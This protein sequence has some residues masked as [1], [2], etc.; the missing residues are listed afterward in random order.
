[1]ANK[2]L[3][4]DSINVLTSYIDQAVS[5][6]TKSGLVLTLQAYKYVPFGETPEIPNGGNYD[7][8][9]GQISWP[10]EGWN[11]LKGVL[12]DIVSDG[13]TIE[14]ALSNGRIY[15]SS[16]VITGTGIPKWSTPIQISGQNGVS[17]QFEYS[18]D[19]NSEQG[20]RTKTPQG[21]NAENRVEYVW[22]RE[23]DG[24][25]STPT[26][27]AMYSQDASN[28]LWKYCVTKDLV[29]PNK[30]SVGDSNWSDD[31]INRN[32][33]GE[34]PYMWM[35]S[36]IVPSGQ[37]AHDGAW[38]TPILFGHWGM[39]GDDGQVPNYSVTFYR[40]TD[41]IDNVP[42]F[43]IAE[44]DL[45]EDVVY[46]NC[47]PENDESQKWYQVP[48]YS[49]NTICWHIVVNVD[50]STDMVTGWS[51]I[52]RYSPLDGDQL[53]TAVT[54]YKYYWSENQNPPTVELEE[55][56]DVPEYKDDEQNGSLWMIT[57]MF[58]INTSNGEEIQVGNWTTP[59]KITGPRGP[60]S[61]DYRIETRYNIG[62]STKPKRLPTEDEWKVTPPATTADYPYVWAINYF[63][64]YKMK[65]D[66][67][68]NADGEYPIVE[69]KILTAVPV[70][71]NGYFR[72]SGLDGED[73]NRRNTIDYV[74]TAKEVK[75]S[76]FSQTNMYISNSDVDTS[77]TIELDQLSFINGYTAKF[78]N[79]GTGYMIINTSE[80]IPFSGSCHHATTVHLDPQ[81]SIELVCY[82]NGNQKELLI[83]GK[84]L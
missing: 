48:T 8:N 60:I 4:L 84:Q 74:T 29:V 81:E 61:Y 77:Y 16:A 59:V 20:T 5:K 38:S 78:C 13:G 32:L 67:T 63:V 39:D 31:L 80:N 69:D 21:V 19:K 51:E 55:Y 6:K 28:V 65:Y 62:T 72:I 1:M 41:S 83:I 43:T 57:G 36:Q 76:S 71:E 14:N 79:I 73:G 7:F 12:D 34:Y 66:D 52:L 50:G 37:D 68:P 2:F 3:G 17:I 35:S 15:V 25:W 53:T 30:P 22:T 23:G 45:F 49:D 33:S 40:A 44:H 42:Q 27:W 64:T 18:Y 26:I 11:S 70:D 75:V 10:A 24:E 47:G 56:K 58:K 9:Y 46:N 54:R 82:N